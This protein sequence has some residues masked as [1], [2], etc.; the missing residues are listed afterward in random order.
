MKKILTIICLLLGFVMQTRAGVPEGVDLKFAYNLRTQ[1]RHYVIRFEQDSLQNLTLNWRIVRN[2]VTL[3]GS[4]HMTAEARQHARM[5][6]Y[7]IPTP[8]ET[9]ECGPNELFALL[10]ADALREVH[11]QQKCQFNNT[12]FQLLGKSS[13]L[14]HL[15]DFD[16]GYEMWVIDDEEFP[17]IWQMENNPVEI[18]WNVEI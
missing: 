10:S 13:N 9:I 1:Y 14:L 3:T 12:T 11:S 18:D 7:V 8:G 2:G 15:K 17:L 16:E 6:S 5:N 4:Y